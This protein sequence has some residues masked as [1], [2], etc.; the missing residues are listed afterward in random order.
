MYL[1]CFTALG[2]AEVIL[3]TL[4]DTLDRTAF[5]PLVVLPGEGLLL[6]ELRRR[7]TRV[8]L[9]PKLRALTRQGGAASRVLL[10]ARDAMRAVRSL[11]Q[12]ARTRQVD[13]VHAAGTDAL[14]YGGPVA[15]LTGIPAV[16][17]LYDDLSLR[18]WL[19]RTAIVTSVSLFY[20]SVMVPSSALREATLRQ[21]ADP[22]KVIT[23]HNGVD[24]RRFSPDPPN[25]ARLRAEL[26]LPPDTPLIGMV[27]RFMPLKGHDVLLRAMAE[28][29]R[30]RADVRCLIV[31]DA[32]FE[33]EA[34]WKRRVLGLAGALGLEGRVI[35]T[36]W[37]SDVPAVLSALDVFV[38]PA[39]AHDSL[40]TVVLEAMAASRPV[41]GAAV[42]G[43]PEMV[44]EGVTGHLPRPGDAKGFAAAI[45]H[46]LAN[47]ATRRAMGAAGRAR[48]LRCFTAERYCRAVETVYAKA[49]SR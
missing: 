42:G 34:E 43:V 12:I 1:D 29:A 46:L 39:T 44:Q 49:L 7:R 25:A 38:H 11:R 19:N 27:G 48:V 35:F 30:Q 36:G 8:L 13:L 6:D 2:G 33:G 16:G 47:P 31:G 5:E 14:K 21:H 15:K 40:P 45:L 17:S 37:R 3:L 32:V 9:E 10:N 20:D 26:G 22:A 4:L 28:V 23:V 24:P 18:P 41:V